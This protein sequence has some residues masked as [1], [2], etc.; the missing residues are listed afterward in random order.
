METIDSN[1]PLFLNPSD[2]PGVT[3]VS[4]PLLGLENYSVWSRS[5]RIALLAKNK[6]GFVDGACRKESYLAV[7]RPQW[8]RCNA[9]VLSW[10]LNSVNQD[11]SAGIVFATSAV[12][13]W[14][15]LKER[16]D[17]VDGSRIYFLHRSIAA[18]I[19]GDVSVSVY[20][21][22]LKLL[23]DEYSALVPFSTCECEVA[24]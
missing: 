2:T 10:I 4:H 12:A 15:D 24:Q 9:V 8:E 23:W 21:T 19:Q 7:L 5:M 17:K 20:Y 1:H 18:M 22:R 13:V 16:F 3:L 14:K 6:L 11:L